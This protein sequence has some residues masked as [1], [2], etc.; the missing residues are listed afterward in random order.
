MCLIN[1]LS[2]FCTLTYLDF[3]EFMLAIFVMSLK[4][5]KFEERFCSRICCKIKRKK[6]KRKLIIVTRKVALFQGFCNI[7]RSH[8]QLHN[9]KK[10][11]RAS[12]I[13]PLK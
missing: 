7:A 4:I 1:R 6:K 13:N 2:K 3:F 12:F 8:I 5:E 10:P 9:E 11:F